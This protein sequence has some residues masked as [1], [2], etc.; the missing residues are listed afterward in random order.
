[1]CRVS[2]RE[3]QIFWMS[4]EGTC[5]GAC[6]DCDGSKKTV[7][8]RI[9]DPI[10]VWK[11]ISKSKTRELTI[12][13]SFLQIGRKQ[14]KLHRVRGGNKLYGFGR[15]VKDLDVEYDPSTGMVGFRTTRDPGIHIVVRLRSNTV[16]ELNHVKKL[17]Y[18]K[19][20]KTKRKHIMADEN[21]STGAGRTRGSA[22][23]PPPPPGAV[24][25]PP[26]EPPKAPPVAKSP[27]EAPAPPTN[28]EAPAPAPPVDPPTTEA[29]AAPAPP[30]APPPKKAPAKAPAKAPEAPV[31]EA[32]VE[33]TEEP[34][35]EEEG[36][37]P[38]E[39]TE[40]IEQD[41]TDFVRDKA[42]L[43]GE[44][45]SAV[46]LS[47]KGW[48]CIPHAH[49]S[50]SIEDIRNTLD[51]LDNIK[52]AYLEALYIIAGKG[53]VSEEQIAAIKEEAVKEFKKK[54]SAL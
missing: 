27:T 31:T 13:N 48:L 33:T 10:A 25:P 49:P 8:A 4:D 32:P 12:T 20:I 43:K 41:W 45:N 40:V 24:A 36:T 30:V 19:Q 3:S 42:P 28:V 47:D 7:L 37:A 53:T 39:S 5:V 38:E 21:K 18:G 44:T 34:E 26:V 51:N 2:A 29:P 6:L 14:F 11:Q 46:K 35:T 23:T 17:F 50:L 22:P 52:G 16:S 1:M 15:F 54:L 9:A